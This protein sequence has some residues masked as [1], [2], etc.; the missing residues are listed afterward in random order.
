MPGGFCA[1]MIAEEDGSFTRTISYEYIRQIAETVH[2]GAKRTG[3][4]IYSRNVEGAAVRNPDGTIGILL[5]NQQKK[6]MPVALRIQGHL[7]E[8]RLPEETLSTV[9][10]SG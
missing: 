2:P 5:L 1:P 10:I 6:S 8:I 7:C 3:I 9:V 4:S